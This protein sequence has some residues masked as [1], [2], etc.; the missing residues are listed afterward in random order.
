GRAHEVGLS[1]TLSQPL[2][3][4]GVMELVWMEVGQAGLTAK[5]PQYL[6]QAPRRSSGGIACRPTGPAGAENALVRRGVVGVTGLEPVTSSLQ[7]TPSA[8]LRSP[9][10]RRFVRAGP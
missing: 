10:L 7:A 8:P 5:T 2:M 1:P 6:N 3:D 9:P 4:E